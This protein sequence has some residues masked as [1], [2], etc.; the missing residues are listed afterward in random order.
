MNDFATWDVQ[1]KDNLTKCKRTRC[2]YGF[3]GYG[4]YVTFG[5]SIVTVT[6]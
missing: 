1:A 5:L 6:K 4:D 3:A 2:G